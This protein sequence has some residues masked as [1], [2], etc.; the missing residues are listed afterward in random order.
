MEMK[1]GHI[2]IHKSRLNLIRMRNL[3]CKDNKIEDRA[4]MNEYWVSVDWMPKKVLSKKECW[5]GLV[6]WIEES[7][8]KQILKE[9]GKGWKREGDWESHQ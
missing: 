9:N 2:N 6:L 8:V 4:K 7:N 1:I 3:T 5:D